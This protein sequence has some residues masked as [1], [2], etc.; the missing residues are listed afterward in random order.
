M[1]TLNSYSI[2]LSQRDAANTTFEEKLLSG[3]RLIIQ[4]DAT[5]N[6]VA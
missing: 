2:I 3:S 5:G 4:T 6:V 1:A